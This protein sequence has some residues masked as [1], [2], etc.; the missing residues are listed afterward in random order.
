LN[1]SD[2][3]NKYL[4][5]LQT[6]IALENVHLRVNPHQQKRKLIFPRH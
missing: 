5:N 3:T 4:V 6:R 1:D 2:F